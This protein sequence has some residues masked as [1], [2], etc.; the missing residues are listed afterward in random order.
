[1]QSAHKNGN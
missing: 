1:M